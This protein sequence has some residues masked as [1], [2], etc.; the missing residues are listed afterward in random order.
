MD[1]D[2]SQLRTLSAVIAEGS[3]EAAAG[4][5]HVTPSAVSQ[6]MRAL[7]AATG[8]VLLI[9]SRPARLTP[10][11]RV[12]LRLAHQIELLTTDAAVELTSSNTG[13]GTPVVAIAVN[14]DSLS[15]W[16]LPALAEVAADVCL[17]LRR[18]D[19]AR[20][21]GLLREGVVVAAVTAEADPVP[22]CTTTRLGRMRYRPAASPAFAARF[23]SAGVDVTALTTAP[24]VVFDRDDDLQDDYLRARSPGAHPPRHHVPASADFLAAVQLGMGWGMVPDMQAAAALS[25]GDLVDLDPTGVIDVTLYW[26]QWKL[27]SSTLQHV[28]TA[29]RTAAADHLY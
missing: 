28:A 8:Q 16:V 29:L 3:L 20:T 6:R 9:R 5:L 14:A 23:F 25:N 22:G 17:D 2:L 7:E 13:L 26:Q 10:P 21:A 1:L 27:R 11:G 15:T 19:Q 12:V 18:E 4:V 24:V